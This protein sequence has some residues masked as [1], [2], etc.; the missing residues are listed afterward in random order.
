MTRMIFCFFGKRMLVKMGIGRNSRDKSVMMFNG[1]DERYTV[2][3]LVHVAESGTGV[4]QAA[5]T[6]RH[7]RM[8]RRVKAS[9]PTLT[10]TSTAIVAQRNILCVFDS[11]R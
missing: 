9:P 4:V 3:M 11:E 1:A 6:G 2:T 7:C 5:L 8:L 10:T